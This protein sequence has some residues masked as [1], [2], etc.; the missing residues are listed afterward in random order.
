MAKAIYKKNLEIIP[1]DV[2]IGQMLCHIIRQPGLSFVV[3]ELLS[4]NPGS[5]F[6][7]KEISEIVGLSFE[8]IMGYS[9]NLIPLGVI[10]KING[11][12]KSLLN[13]GEGFI[14]EG[15]DKLIFVAGCEN[16]CEELK[17]KGKFKKY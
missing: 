11:E 16:D 15:G 5:E 2:I 9:K 4:H 1:G 8:Q 7:V 12:N 3:K 6:Y 13:P 10:R 17:R 14:V